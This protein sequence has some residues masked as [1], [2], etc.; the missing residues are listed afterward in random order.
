MALLIGVWNEPDTGNWI[1]PSAG[2]TARKGARFGLGL[3]RTVTKRLRENGTSYLKTSVRI[4]M[5][6]L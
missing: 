3:L 1:P 5:I 2:M 6:F 4:L